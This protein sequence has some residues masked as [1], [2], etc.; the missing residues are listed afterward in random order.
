MTRV[1]PT[2]PHISRI[3]LL[4]LPAL[5][6]CVTLIAYLPA[7]RGGFIWDDD[8]HVTRP[9]LRSLH[10]LWLIWFHPGST[11]QYYPLLESAFWVQHRLWGDR[12][13]G[14]HLVNIL[15]HAAAACL[16]YGLLRRL[17]IPGAYLAAA[18]FALHPVQVE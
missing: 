14:Y 9:G 17:K 4:G 12:P 5:L 2:P 8:A 16:V 3:W 6:V 18:V 1:E 15:L 7:A 11:Q 13:V 10:G